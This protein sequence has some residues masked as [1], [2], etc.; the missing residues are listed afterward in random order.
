[1]NKVL[2]IIL[3]ADF[4]KTLEF[5][6]I[7]ICVAII[8]KITNKI[9][10]KA[11]IG[12]S[13]KGLKRV[14]DHLNQ[15][16]RCPAIVSAVKKYGKESF[17][18]EVLFEHSDPNY[19][20]NVME[21]FFIKKH[22]TLSPNGYNLTGGGEGSLGRKVSKKSLERFLKMINDQKNDINF[23]EKLR[24]TARNRKGYKHNNEAKV[25]CSIR[26]K[27]W[28][29]TASLEVREVYFQKTKIGN[30]KRSKPVEFNGI[31]YPSLRE[32]ARQIGRD[33]DYVKARCRFITVE[34]YLQSIKTSS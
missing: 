26:R 5:L 13:T 6:R 15:T 17:E 28:W 19:T 4:L 20:L 2:T 33:R 24:E 34:E 8:Y 18:V 10:N 32:T 23:K 9:N 7:N 21:P 27:E 30:L 11:Y 1:M 12:H 31:C 16:S 14:Q 29:E 3:S 25:K 22:N